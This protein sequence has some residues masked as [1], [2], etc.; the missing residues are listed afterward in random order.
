MR[1]IANLLN[2][3]GRIYIFIRSESLRKLLQ[4]NAG[5]EGFTVYGINSD[6]FI[7]KDDWTLRGVGFVDH[8]CFHSMVNTM[9]D[10]RKIYRVDYGKYLAGEK[11]YF[12]KKTKKISE[13]RGF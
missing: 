8:M 7:L 11:R 12:Y 2:H 10:G 13:K 4:K 5:Q 1:T 9:G 6:L 3:K